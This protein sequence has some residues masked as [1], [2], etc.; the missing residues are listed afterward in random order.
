MLSPIYIPNDYSG[1]V[2]EEKEIIAKAVDDADVELGPIQ[3]IS[4]KSF[5]R[6]DSEWE[7]K[8][9]HYTIFNIPVRESDIT[10]A[11]SEDG[12]HATDGSFKDL[13]PL[14]SWIILLSA[15]VTFFIVFVLPVLSIGYLI[16]KKWRFSPLLRNPKTYGLLGYILVAAPSLLFYFEVIAGIRY[17]PATHITE[18]TWQ[19]TYQP[20]YLYLISGA[21]VAAIGCYRSAFMAWL[22]SILV[23]A[24][25]I[26]L[27]FRAGL[28][29]FI[30]AIVLL[31]G[32]AVMTINK[33]KVSKRDEQ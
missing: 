20:F 10:V 16:N 18:T 8:I 29:P 27:I 21:T 26:S 22:G 11:R 15:I 24:L 33:T 30:G 7:I 13:I 9:I 31:A 25:S 1:Y 19:G 2:G 28:L 12:F 17:Y 6:Y 14:A 4:V 5:I 23:L 32:A 3:R